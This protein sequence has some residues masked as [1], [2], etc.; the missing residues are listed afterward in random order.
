M[1][2]ALTFSLLTTISHVQVL[3]S[4]SS[5]FEVGCCVLYAEPTKSSSLSLKISEDADK[6]KVNLGA[7][8]KF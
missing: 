7:K 4:V 8:W 1:I 6:F 5:A 2:S 3:P